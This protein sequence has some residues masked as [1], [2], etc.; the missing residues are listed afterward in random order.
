MRLADGGSWSANS[1]GQSGVCHGR[2]R[3][4]TVRSTKQPDSGCQRQRG[5]PQV[6]FGEPAAQGGAG[7]GSGGGSARAGEAQRLRLRQRFAGQAPAGPGCERSGRTDSKAVPAH[8]GGDGGLAARER[9]APGEHR[10]RTASMRGRD[11]GREQAGRLR[12]GRVARRE[13]SAAGNDRVEPGDPASVFAGANGGAER[14]D[15][16][17]ERRDGNGK[18]TCGGGG[19]PIEPPREAAVRGAE[20]R[21]NSGG[22]AGGG[23][24]RTCARSV[25][26]GGAVAAGPDPRGAGGHAV[27]RRDRGTAAEHASEAAE[28]SAERR[29]AKAGELGC[30]SRGCAGNLRD[31]RAVDGISAGEAVPAGLVLPA[32]GVS[33]RA[34]AAAAARRRY[35][36]AGAAFSGE[37]ERGIE[38]AGE[39]ADGRIAIAAGSASVGRERTGVATR[40]GAGVHPFGER[41]SVGAG[42]FQVVRRDSELRE[43]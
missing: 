37:A 28:I 25:Y 36:T 35:W 12:S 43:I 26:R 31:E 42:I 13:R 39:E 22:A 2:N 19:A 34:A 1:A 21:G 27:P 29:S 23:T 40:A 10:R 30:I 6:S 5:I 14:Y 17:A 8:R 4:D 11:D 24:F 16:A 20:L 33:D 38:T 3:V 32:G 15:G 41:G 9:D 7:G 18:R